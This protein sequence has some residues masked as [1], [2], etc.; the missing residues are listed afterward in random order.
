VYPAQLPVAASMG[1]AGIGGVHCRIRTESP[2]EECCEPCRHGK[3]RGAEGSIFCK[4]N[5][6]RSGF[7][8]QTLLALPEDSMDTDEVRRHS[9]AA[10]RFASHVHL[11][12]EQDGYVEG[13]R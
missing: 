9:D 3:N 10:A 2:V 13:P 7:C 11:A 5:D 4:S 6:N 1:P 8:G 12:S